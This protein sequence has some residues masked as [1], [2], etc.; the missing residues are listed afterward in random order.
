MQ[1]TGSGV[2]RHP[3]TAAAHATA[4]HGGQLSG[5]T[6][7]SPTALHPQLVWPIDRTYRGRAGNIIGMII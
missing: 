1:W 3:A 2:A 5:Y 4:F 7:L 6:P